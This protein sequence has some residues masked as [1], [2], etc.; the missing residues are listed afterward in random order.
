MISHAEPIA[1]A[2]SR[3]TG[4]ISMTVSSVQATLSTAA[5]TPSAAATR[6]RLAND[7][8]PGVSPAF[9][10]SMISSVNAA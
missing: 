10:S 2:Q 8:G 7:N 9:R 5:A 3:S 1:M 6:N 4:P